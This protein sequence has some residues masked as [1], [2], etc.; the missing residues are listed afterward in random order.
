M[1]KVVEIHTYYGDSHILKG[2]SL[3]VGDQSLVAILG[4]NGMGKTTLVRSINGFTPPRRGRIYFKDVEITHLPA[5]R[6]TQMGISIVPQG[7]RIFP[8][9]TVKENLSIAARGGKKERDRNIGNILAMFPLLK[10]RLSHRGNELSGGEQQMLAIGRALVGKPDCILL[11]EPSE[12]LAPLLIENITKAILEM[13]KLGLSMLLVEQDFATA[14]ELADYICIMSKGQIVHG[15]E[16]GALADN[17]DVKK[18]YLGVG[19]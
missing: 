12:G 18:K 3:E 5:H 13:K 10:E 1:L 6:I 15:S 8:S 14:L 16:P 9:L 11:D 17:E 2:V 19:E 7:R 4:R